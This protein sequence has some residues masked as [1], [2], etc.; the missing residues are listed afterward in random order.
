LLTLVTVGIYR[1]WARTR[2]RRFYW[3]SIEIA[4]DPLE[5]TGR[6]LELFLGFL[7]VLVVLLPLVVGLTALQNILA[8]QAPAYVAI[9]QIVFFVLVW[10]LIGYA[11]F[12]A[13]RYRLT[14]TLWR[15]IR[16]GQ[17]GSP[18]RYAWMRFGWTLAAIASLGIAVPWYHVAL[19]RYEMRH[20]RFGFSR[21]DYVGKGRDLFRYWWPVIVSGLVLFAGFGLFVAGMER[22]EA[23]GGLEQGA[24]GQM[25]IPFAKIG[26][27]PMTTGGVIAGFAGMVLY[28]LT[29]ARYRVESLRYLF[30][31]SSIEG[32]T[33]RSRVSLWRVFLYALIMFGVVILTFAALGAYLGAAVAA[34]A[35]G[36]GGVAGAV[37]VPLVIG[38]M[39]LLTIVQRVF[40]EFPLV[41][42]VVSTLE[43]SDLA[44][45]DRVVQATREDPRFGEGLLD[46]LDVEI[47]VA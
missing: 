18:M 7:I 1:F 8:V 26:E 35:A 42:H 29:Q 27:S 25:A 36:Q 43:L 23:G 3:Q 41:R 33:C 34:A 16:C 14:R 40:F 30:A 15:G 44:A 10:W 31:V 17:D 45:L 11:V 47:D 19:R 24:Q 4:D 9:S 12:R 13:R 20:T 32:V 22:L 6:G 2:L 46:A 28:V 38:A 37:A 21:F 39:L 5:Y